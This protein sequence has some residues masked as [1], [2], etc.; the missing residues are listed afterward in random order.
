MTRPRPI[1]Q[2]TFDSLDAM[3]QAWAAEAV[4]IAAEDHGMNLDFSPDSIARLE[5]VLAARSPVPAD[6]QDEATRL[7]GAYYGEIFRRKYPA[8]WIMA[9]YPGQLN[10]GRSDAGQEMAMPAL[11]IRGSQ[12]Y[13]LLKVFRRLTMGPKEDLSAFYA[14]VTSALDATRS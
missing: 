3:M 13:P 6:Q 14:K 5:T 1:S 11:N 8:D 9:V 4:R 7:W 12:V 10:S 2:Q